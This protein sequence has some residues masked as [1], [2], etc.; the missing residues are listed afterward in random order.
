MN[1]SPVELSGPGISPGAEQMPLTTEERLWDLAILLSQERG[2][3][4]SVLEIELDEM[5]AQN[6]NILTKHQREERAARELAYAQG[7]ER[8][9]ELAETELAV[10]G[11][12]ER[13][14]EGT[15]DPDEIAAYLPPEQP[16]EDQH[17]VS[18]RKLAIWHE[19]AVTGVDPRS[20]PDGPLGPWQS[21]GLPTTGRHQRSVTLSGNSTEPEAAVDRFFTETT[22]TH[23][24][25]FRMKSRSGSQ[26]KYTN[27]AGKRVRKR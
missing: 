18:S 6:P 9:Y 10:L 19:A 5:A 15:A 1:L 24:G 21:R 13:M 8:A 27:A 4:Q 11:L 26:V 17:Q 20:A 7:A 2:A 3:L 22:D 12:L 23:G 16:A 14:A 25:K